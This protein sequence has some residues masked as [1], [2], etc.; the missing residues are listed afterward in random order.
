M[1]YTEIDGKRYE[2][3]ACR[4]CPFRDMG[5]SGYAPQCTHPDVEPNIDDMPWIEAGG[6]SIPEGCPLREL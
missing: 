6:I 5:G 1:R 3:G 4:E 2:V